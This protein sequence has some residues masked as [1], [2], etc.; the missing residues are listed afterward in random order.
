MPAEDTDYMD[1]LVRLQVLQ[2]R[3]SHESQ[4]ETIIELADAGFSSARIAEL[5]GTSPAT[6]RN[7]LARAK[8]SRGSD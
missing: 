8:K 2:L 4:A 7:A 1:Q 3:R 6:V 5:L